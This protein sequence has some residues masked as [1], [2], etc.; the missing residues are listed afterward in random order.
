MVRFVSSTRNLMWFPLLGVVVFS[1]TFVFTEHSHAQQLNPLAGAYIEL[2]PKYPLAGDEVKADFKAASIDMNVS[3]I[4]WKIN[5]EVVAQG[6]G[7]RSHTF[8]AGKAGDAFAIEVTA[9]PPRGAGVRATKVVRVSD[10]SYT[11]EGRTYTPPFFTG[12]ALVSRQAEATVVVFPTVY[13]AAGK[14]YDPDVLVYEWMLNGV[15]LLEK[16]GRGMNSAVLKTDKL[17]DDFGVTLTIK[18]PF[19][20]IRVFKFIKL[21]ITEPRI[22]FY[23]DN[24]LLGIQYAFALDESVSLPGEEMRLVAEP[25]YASAITRVDPQLSYEWSV[26]G[27]TLTT[28][29]SLV[30]RLDGVGAGQTQLG[31]TVLNSTMFAQRLQERLQIH[32]GQT[33]AT[34]VNPSTQPL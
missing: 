16:S 2:D 21:P 30:L 9:T 15:K 18:D 32:Y 13:D 25:Y 8:T 7:K 27:D 33:G 26:S 20:E 14:L 29:G 1:A 22:I 17:Y 4:T 31:L 5:G 10:L 34:R 19:G 11:W 12:R 23:E 28:P 24:P 3:Q 6:Y